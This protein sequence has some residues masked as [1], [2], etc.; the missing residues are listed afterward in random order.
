MESP[1]VTQ[2]I[3]D[4]NVGAAIMQAASIGSTAHM[5]TILNRLNEL[6]EVKEGLGMQ[7]LEI[8]GGEVK[9][10]LTREEAAVEV[11]TPGVIRVEVEYDLPDELVAWA[12][13]ATPRNNE[14]SHN[15]DDYM[16]HRVRNESHFMAPDCPKLCHDCD[17][18]FLP[19]YVVTGEEQRM[20]VEMSVYEY[21]FLD[22]A[23]APL[24]LTVAEYLREL[25]RTD[26]G[27]DLYLPCHACGYDWPEAKAYDRKHGRD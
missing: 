18:P 10:E 19:P 22:H 5:Q 23:S 6:Y 27:L 20:Q 1:G 7:Y 24:G 21:N 8:V 14:E 26:W 4:G 3:E 13:T 11:N 12:D 15:A 16:M 2:A 9:R 25:V 17:Q